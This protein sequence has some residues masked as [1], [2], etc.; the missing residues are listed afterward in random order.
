MSGV[1]W[2]AEVN[3]L[4]IGSSNSIACPF[5]IQRTSGLLVRFAAQLLL[6]RERSSAAGTHVC[7]SG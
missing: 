6:R 3:R 4:S 5:D 2:S 1:E 7:I